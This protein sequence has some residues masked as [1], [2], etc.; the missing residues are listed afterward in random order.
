MPSRGRRT[1]EHDPVEL[2]GA[3]IGQGGI[4]AVVLHP[5]L[6]RK[7]GVGP[8]DTR[9][10]DGQLAI[11]RQEDAYA[12]RIDHHGCRTLH[13]V[14][15]RLEADP[16]AGVARHRP[17]VQ[18]QVQVL[19]HAGRREHRHHRGGELVI[20]L[21]GQARRARGMVI[22][23]YDQH[24]AVLRSA[25]IVGVL[26]DVAAA[27]HPRP[28]PVPEREHAVVAGAGVEIHLLAA[29]CGGRGQVLVQTRP[30]ADV[31]RLEMLL[32]APQRFV[33]RR[34]R[35]TPVAGDE[36]GRIE[37]GREIALAL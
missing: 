14:G 5:P 15:Q 33:E 8:A 32:R 28:F 22:A 10:I 18:P 37:P 1:V 23:G 21:I 25:G 36:T 3:R 2:V 13:G 7:T 9:S 26:E 19:L 4:D 31:G 27:V 11:L 12:V 16:A 30:K 34:D 24:P 35:R 6:L 17:A 29:P 20:A